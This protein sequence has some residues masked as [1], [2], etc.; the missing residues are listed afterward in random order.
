MPEDRSD[1]A[2]QTLDPRHLL[3]DWANRQDSWVRRLVGHVIA[4]QRP[5]S[6]GQATELFELFL[7]EKGFHGSSSEIEPET[8]LSTGRTGPLRSAAVAVLVEGIGSQRSQPGR[9]HRLQSGADDSLWG[10]RHG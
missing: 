1:D 4:S 10:E 6:D 2:S 9:S 3:I 7:A 5:I 8:P